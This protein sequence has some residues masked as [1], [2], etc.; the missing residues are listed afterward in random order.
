MHKK[1]FFYDGVRWEPTKVQSGDTLVLE[2]D[3]THAMLYRNGT[4]VNSHGK[5]ATQF[6]HA[7]LKCGTA[8]DALDGRHCMPPMS[9]GDF[10]ETVRLIAAMLGMAAVEDWR[11][12]PNVAMTFLSYEE[13]GRL[14]E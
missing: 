3:V 11:F 6:P 14:K 8:A 2:P 1:L 7:E 9:N 10:Q 13:A 4:Q 12:A 5:L